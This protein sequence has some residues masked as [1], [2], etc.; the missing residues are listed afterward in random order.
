[1]NKVQ[2]SELFNLRAIQRDYLAKLLHE[3]KGH[4]YLV[5][6]PYTMD[7]L[8]VA[9]FRSELYAFNV[10]DTMLIQNI[11]S[12]TTQGSVSGVFILRPNDENLSALTQMLNNPPFEKLYICT[13]R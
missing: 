7:C 13:L 9:Y 8:S 12:L 5:L 1:M 3:Q 6:D 2:A 11:E 4:K 10:F